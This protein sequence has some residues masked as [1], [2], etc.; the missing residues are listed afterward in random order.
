MSIDTKA[1]GML[2][3]IISLLA[4]LPYIGAILQGKTK[5]NR[6]SWWIWA[7]IGMILAISYHA[8]GAHTTIWVPI[9]YVIGPTITALLSIKYGEGGWNTLD[10]ACLTGAFISLVI[11]WL[12]K[13]PVLALFINLFIDLLGALPTLVKSY[14]DPESEDRTA[15]LLFVTGNTVNLFALKKWTIILAAYPVY[16][17]AVSGLIAIFVCFRPRKTQ[18]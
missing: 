13:S 1:I 14:S 10:R 9:S 17:V 3:G 4:F 11:W 6:A 5:P 2:A 16:M 15:W 8:S 18:K 7:T 12:S